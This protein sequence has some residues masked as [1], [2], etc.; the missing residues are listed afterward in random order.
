MSKEKPYFMTCT[1]MNPNCEKYN[2]ANEPVHS[3]NINGSV[4]SY[5]KKNLHDTGY[6]LLTRF[7]CNQGVC[8]I[9]NVE[10]ETK[11]EDTDIILR[12]E[13][14]QTVIHST[15]DAKK[16]KKYYTRYTSKAGG[17][18]EAITTTKGGGRHFK[19]Q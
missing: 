14:H 13:L 7:T 11:Y 10:M 5:Y 1:C 18:P 3:D 8:S 17:I 16:S 4:R 2:I 9:C 6:S 19:D 15:C 12:P